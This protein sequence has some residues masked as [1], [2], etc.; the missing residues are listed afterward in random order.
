VPLVRHGA[1]F[2]CALVAGCAVTAIDH[3]SGPPE[4]WPALAVTV[5]ERAPEFDTACKVSSHAMPV[6]GCTVA[7][8]ERRT[9]NI[10]LR[11]SADAVLDH[12]RLHCLGYDHAGE[13][14]LRTAWARYK[15]REQL[16]TATRLTALPGVQTIK[17]NGID[18]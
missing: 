12:E 17:G 13:A 10:Y 9:C 16:R 11:F 18:P 2:A 15:E 1:L 14:G 7:N 5:H 4:D 3:E 8:F 6:L